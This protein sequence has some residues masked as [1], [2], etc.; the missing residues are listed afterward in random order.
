MRAFIL[1]LLLAAGCIPVVEPSPPIA[2]QE[3][4]VE[5]IWDRIFYVNYASP[6]IIVWVAGDA[7]PAC[8]GT[9]FE[10]TYHVELEVCSSLAASW[11][12]EGL[13]A[14]WMAEEPPSF[15]DRE[16]EARVVWGRATLASAGL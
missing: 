12:I 15:S 5:M 3:R 14:A 4:A 7:D 8:T 9:F 11:L 13:C 6:P 1:A 2:G 16:C 10:G